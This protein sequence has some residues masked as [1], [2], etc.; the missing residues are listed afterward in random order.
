MMKDR[1]VVV[2]GIGVVSSVGIG[3]DAFWNSIVN[4]ACGLSEVSAFDTSGF[5]CHRGGEVKNFLPGEFMPKHKI[6]FLSRTSQ[7][8]IAASAL[9]LKDAGVPIEKISG[10]K[11]G[12]IIGTTLGETYIED[13]AAAWAR[14]GLKDVQRRKLFQASVN[15]IS[16]NVGIQFKAMGVN[17]LIPNACAAGNY[18]IGYA[19]DLIKNG[20]LN[21]VLAGGSEAFSCLAFAG[22]QRLYAMSPDKCAPFDKNRKG[23][24]L[25][26]GSGILLI[27]SLESARKRGANVYAEILGYGL[28]CDAYHATAT[29][30]EGIA[31]V[32]RK[33]LKDAAIDREEVDYICA[34]GT[35][36][37]MNDKTESKAINEVFGK[38]QGLMVS[39]LKSMLGHTMGASSAIASAACCLAI[40]DGI[41]PPT[42]NFETPDPECDIDCVANIARKI[43]INIALNNGFAFGGNNC[44]V[45]FSKANL[46]IS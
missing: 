38:R 21:F 41:V 35:G 18:A 13:L 16:A 25:G 11:L 12:V 6:K 8:A 30:P 19:F 39:S 42:I 15:N 29:E 33:A 34:H 5:T 1:R 2:T 14:G 43:K 31:K 46:E 45:V 26:E 32:M 10:D 23:M 7:L 36:T 40:K 44:S 9:A 20:D 22:F 24:M 3:R 27:E 28:S 4:G 37:P 17:Y